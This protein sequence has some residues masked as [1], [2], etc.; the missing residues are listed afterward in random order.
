M[1]VFPNETLLLTSSQLNLTCEAE[2]PVLIHLVAFGQIE[3]EYYDERDDLELEPEH[4]EMD[5][6][7][8]SETTEH[9]ELQSH[10]ANYIDLNPA[11]GDVGEFQCL[12]E[13]DGH[14]FHSWIFQIISK[15]AVNA[16]N[17]NGDAV[18]LLNYR[19]FLNKLC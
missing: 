12:S 19:R 3:P 2:E 10:V 14:V 17:S 11:L 6:I 16:E 8:E 15:H 13:V 1:K 18:L 4:H 7:E 5:D 9:T